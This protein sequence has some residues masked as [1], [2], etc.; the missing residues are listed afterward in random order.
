MSLT[1]RVSFDDLMDEVEPYHLQQRQ[2]KD[3]LQS[4]GQRQGEEISEY[5]HRI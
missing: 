3:D 1:R 2:A 5:Y 4:I